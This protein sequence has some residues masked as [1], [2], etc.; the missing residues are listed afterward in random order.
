MNR[1]KDPWV[2][3]KIS[4]IHIVKAPEEET[5]K[6]KKIFG[7]VMTENFPNFTKDKASYSYPWHVCYCL[8]LEMTCYFCPHSIDQRKSLNLAQGSTYSIFIISVL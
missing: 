7:D 5:M 3:R 2:N 4:K 6:V 1:L 8:G